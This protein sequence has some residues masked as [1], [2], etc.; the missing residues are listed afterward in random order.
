MESRLITRSNY[1]AYIECCS[2][3]IC[4]ANSR[5]PVARFLFADTR[6]ALLWLIV[7]LYVGYQWL[8]VHKASTYLQATVGHI[9]EGLVAAPMHDLKLALG[10]SVVVDTDA[11]T[12]IVQVAEQ[13]AET[14]ADTKQPY[15]M[16]VMAT[17]GR[18]GLQRWAMGSVTERVLNSTRLPI[19]VVHPRELASTSEPM[20]QKATIVV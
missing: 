6:I 4:N 15:D 16:V 3:E 9:E 14:G 20:W 13:G 19:L 11:A 1:H 5:T 8:L 18:G 2:T 17:H 10:W 7:R 12:A